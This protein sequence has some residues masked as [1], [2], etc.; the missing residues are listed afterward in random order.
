MA[1]EN[2]QIIG[3]QIMIDCNNIESLAGVMQHSCLSMN[4]LVCEIIPI[5]TVSKTTVQITWN[6]AKY[7]N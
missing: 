3:D 6:K 7:I 2:T 4:E 5:W 1:K